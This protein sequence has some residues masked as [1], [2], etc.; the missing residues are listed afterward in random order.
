MHW[1]NA[2]SPLKF[3]GGLCRFAKTFHKQAAN[4]KVYAVVVNAAQITRIGEEF[5]GS[6]NFRKSDWKKVG[7]QIIERSYHSDCGNI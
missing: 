3:A 7:N 5:R 1:K 6:W 2:P 4:A